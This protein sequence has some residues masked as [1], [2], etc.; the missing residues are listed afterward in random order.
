MRNAMTAMFVSCDR[1]LRGHV[2]FSPWTQGAAA[3][4]ARDELA[5]L[6]FDSGHAGLAVPSLRLANPATATQ[7]ASAWTS[8]WG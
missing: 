5:P 2:S 4:S 6:R 7:S 8:Q 3:E 1:L